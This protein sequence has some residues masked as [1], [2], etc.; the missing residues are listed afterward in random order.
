MSNHKI[1]QIIADSCAEL[2]AK[3]ELSWAMWKL[4]ILPSLRIA[5]FKH[6]RTS[7]VSYP[8]FVR[9][10]TQYHNSYNLLILTKSTVGISL[11]GSCFIIRHLAM[12]VVKYIVI[13]II[14]VFCFYQLFCW[15][16][17]FCSFI[18]LIRSCNGTKL[19]NRYAY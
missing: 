1:N 14:F 10:S 17:G 2:R 6:G 7:C 19:A 11:R 4:K 9:R 12:F 8:L 3:S 16:F 13:Q 5:D 18:S 15:P